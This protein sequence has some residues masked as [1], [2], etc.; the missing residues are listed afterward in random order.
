MSC[1][2]IVTDC[3]TGFQVISDKPA[4]ASNSLNGC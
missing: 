3:G 2:F 1:F 4:L